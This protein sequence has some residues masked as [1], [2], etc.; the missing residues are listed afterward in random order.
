MWNRE[1]IIGIASIL[2]SIA[3]GWM[4][5]NFGHTALALTLAAILFFGGIGLLTYG[6][7]FKK[8]QK[9]AE[10]S[11]QTGVSIF[12]QRVI[13]RGKIISQGQGAKTTIVSKDI[14]NTGTI[15]SKAK[16]TRNNTRTG[17]MG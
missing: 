5:E 10:P 2:I 14:K 16:E 9:P 11:S 7:K 1:T 3:G 13:N 12:A 6:L 15:E 17:K 8:T 4:L